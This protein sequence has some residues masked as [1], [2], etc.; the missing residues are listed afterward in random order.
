MQQQKGSRT[1]RGASTAALLRSGSYGSSWK[2]REQQGGTSDEWVVS[3][4]DVLLGCQE[5]VCSA[6]SGVLLVGVVAC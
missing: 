2:R 1:C 6:C 5:K 4:H 3:V